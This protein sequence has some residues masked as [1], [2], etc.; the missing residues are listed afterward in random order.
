VRLSRQPG[1]CAPHQNLAEQAAERALVALD[2]PS[3]RRVIRSLIASD[4]TARDIL[5]A[6]PLDPSRERIP[7]DQQYKIS[8]HHRR[9]VR[10][11]AETVLASPAYNADRS[12][13]PTTSITNP[14]RWSC[15]SQSR[16][17]GGSRNDRSRSRVKQS[18]SCCGYS[19]QSANFDG[20]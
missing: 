20:L 9:L 6:G 7:R 12:V 1:V 15:G 16:K 4:H 14:T 11:T 8:A 2:E 19:T 3:D 18:G 13:T 10:R 17:S 5:Q